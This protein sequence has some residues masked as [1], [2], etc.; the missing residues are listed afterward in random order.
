MPDTFSK[1]SNN[2]RT[3][4]NNPD[5]SQANWPNSNKNRYINGAM[6]VDGDAVYI[7][8]NQSDYSLSFGWLLGTYAY[9]SNKGGKPIICCYISKELVDKKDVSAIEIVKVLLAISIPDLGQTF[10]EFIATG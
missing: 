2:S 9:D 6:Y 1:V 8:I 4:N 5:N 7:D 3:S 10:P